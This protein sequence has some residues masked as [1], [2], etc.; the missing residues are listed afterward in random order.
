MKNSSQTKKNASR[1]ALT[2]RRKKRLTSRRTPRRSTSRGVRNGARRLRGGVY[3]TLESADASRQRKDAQFQSLKNAQNEDLRRR[4]EAKTFIDDGNLEKSRDR[5]EAIR[6][7]RSDREYQQSRD[8]AEKA[9]ERAVASKDAYAR[10]QAAE[11]S[12]RDREYQ[13]SRD[14][15]EKAYYRAV[16][17]KDAYARFQAA[18]ASDASEA[19]EASEA[20]RA[21]QLLMAQKAARLAALRDPDIGAGAAEYMRLVTEQH[22]DGF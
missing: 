10:F 12:N 20:R 11:A 13:K 4:A 3:T 1:N 15:A 2:P 22:G 5:R 18:E 6:Q 16:A 7:R 17:S 8:T 19:S 9:Y 21:H 14:T